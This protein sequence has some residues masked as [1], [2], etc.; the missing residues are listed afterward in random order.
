MFW[1][2]GILGLALAVAPWVLSYSDNSTAMWTSVIAGALVAL[3]SAYKAWVQ[4]T[5]QNWEYWAVGVIG[6]AAI[7][8]PF[9][10]QFSALTEALW[11]SVIVGALLIVA[12]GYQ[13]F[14]VPM[15]KP[16]T[17]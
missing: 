13:V 10:L 12:V 3:A 1:V 4:D 11:T 15:Q 8:A 14:F 6:I 2:T 9:L 7:A 16:H 17:S 5:D